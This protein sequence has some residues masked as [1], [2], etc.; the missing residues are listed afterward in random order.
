M[1]KMIAAFGLIVLMSYEINAQETPLKSQ[2]LYTSDRLEVIGSKMR[3][4]IVRGKE[5]KKEDFQVTEAPDGS[6]IIRAKTPVYNAGFLV[7]KVDKDRI[8][9]AL[10]TE[11]GKKKAVPAG[12]T[13]APPDIQILPWSP[14]KKGGDLTV[15]VKPPK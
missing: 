7:E 13:E 4:T 6:I 2:W 3:I 12:L 9:S 1:A 8:T 10:F 14:D 5:V 15:T 11:E